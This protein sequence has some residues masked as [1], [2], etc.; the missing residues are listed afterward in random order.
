MEISEAR[1]FVIPVGKHAGRTVQAVADSEDRIDLETIL[2]TASD[3]GLLGEDELA[4]AIEAV[5]SGVGD[6]A[7]VTADEET[8]D[9]IKSEEETTDVKSD[10]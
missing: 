2:E 6:E 8:S 5:L 1:S 10:D 4:Q 9:D 3:S 7:P